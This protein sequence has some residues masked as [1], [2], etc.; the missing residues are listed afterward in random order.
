MI[1]PSFF[2]GLNFYIEYEFVIFALK[3]IFIIY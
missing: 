3:I 1:N 2:V